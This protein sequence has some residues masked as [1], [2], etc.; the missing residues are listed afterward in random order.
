MVEF[1]LDLAA[2]ADRSGDLALEGHGV[3]TSDFL[4]KPV[5]FEFSDGSVD[6]GGG[7]LTIEDGSFTVSEDL[8][9]L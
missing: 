5:T 2:A 6:F 9:F 1:L 4:D 8:N 3:V 7:S